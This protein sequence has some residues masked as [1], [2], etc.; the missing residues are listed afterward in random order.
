MKYGTVGIILACLWT[1]ACGGD[2]L[3]GLQFACD[4]ALPES[5]GAGYWCEPSSGVVY[6]GVCKPLGS[7]TH[8][9]PG[10]TD[11]IAGPTDVPDVPADVGDTAEIPDDAG[12]QLPDDAGTQLHDDT[13][14]GTD[15]THDT[16]DLSNE[17]EGE[18]GSISPGS[19]GASCIYNSDCTSGFCIDG[20]SGRVCTISCVDTC[21]DGWT[22]ETS[23]MGE[24]P[25]SLCQPAEPCVPG[26][27]VC[28]GLDDDCNDATDDGT[29][30]CDDGYTCT[31]DTC[32][33]VKG[34]SSAVTSG[35][36]LIE[37]QCRAEGQANPSNAC[38]VCSPGKTKT[39]WSPAVDGT[40]CGTRLGCDTGRCLPEMV[41]VPAGAFWMGA[42]R[43]GTQCPANALD[44]GARADET[45]CHQVTL[46][47]FRVDKY[48]VTVAA[49]KT[50]VDAGGCTVPACTHALK[51]WGVAGKEQHPMTCL[52]WIHADAYCR[53]AGRRLCSES[54]WERAARG[55]D[56]RMYPW[57]NQTPTCQYAVMNE[58]GEGCG[59]NSTAVVGSKAAG[60]SP[61]GA[62]DMV[63]NASELVEDDWHPGYTGAPTDGTAWLDTPRTGSRIERGRGLTSIGG[64]LTVTIREEISADASDTINGARCCR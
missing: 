27:E 30:L 47:A 18:D 40:A 15:Q 55:S 2:P 48:E 56:G 21:P 13:T 22:C 61:Y 4:P 58:G 53:W 14:G 31:Q 37:G 35:N 29:S 54:Q 36:C 45:P 28:N 62:L 64:V 11:D 38:E 10:S 33:G 23:R 52:S 1:I 5:C 42:N 8:T 46:Q 25:Y 43:D 26:E 9:D 41:S 17:T 51:T 7:M 19:F 16:S 3:S 24:D 20:D 59:T 44:T 39:S 60:A 34:C 57:G 63:G 32:E 50:C 6:R 12:N 49:Y